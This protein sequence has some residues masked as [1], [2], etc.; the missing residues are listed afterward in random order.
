MIH[1]QSNTVAIKSPCTGVCQ[2]SSLDVCIGCGRLREEIA[3]WSALDSASQQ[4]V[5]SESKKR[6]HGRRRLTKPTSAF[7]LIELLVVV[8]IVGILVSLLLPAVQSVR[9]AARQTS[10]KNNMRQLGIGLHNYHDTH[11]TLPPG[12]IEWRASNAHPTRRQF[13]WS[14][15]LLPFIEQQNVHQQIHWGRPFDALENR[16]ISQI[17]LAVYLCPSEPDLEPGKGLISYGGI[18]GELIVD[19]QQDDGL[20][21]Y[22][23]AFRFR[24][25]LDGLTN[26]LAVSEDVGGPDRQWI[27]GRNVF[28]VA[29][30]IDDPEAWAGDNEIRSAH[31]GGAITLF[32]DSRTNFLSESIDKQLL[33]KLIT[34]SKREV[35]DLP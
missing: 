6:L 31:R 8:G 35:V 3:T 34:R 22:D 26:T 29:H 1:P 24:D 12:C 25:I 33:G 16:Q 5:V 17:D 28:A 21:V 20:F 13:A 23:R 19:R 9:E 32:A 18:Y 30:G 10:C 15:L 11:R 2:L 4:R 27:N 14:A 7:T